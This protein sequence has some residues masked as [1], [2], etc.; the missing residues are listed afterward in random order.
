M[1]KFILSTLAIL[2]IGFAVPTFAQEQNIVTPRVR[3]EI[4]AVFKKFQEAYDKRDAAALAALYTEDAVEVRLW[5][6]AQGGGTFFGRQ[7]IEKMFE[8]AFAKDPAKVTS[9]I[10][11][12]HMVG[13]GVY[14]IVNMS[15][16]TSVGW[17]L[18]TYVPD[19]ASAD[20]WKICMTF[21]SS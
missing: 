1:K 13:E 21:I 18:Q 2:A 3:E 11:N 5:G 16:G 6:A 14:V 8:T 9:E 4:E 10:V 7:T 19:D 15:F 20:L 12:A 17:G